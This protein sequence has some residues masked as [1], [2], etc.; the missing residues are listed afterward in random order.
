MTD[1]IDDEKPMSTEEY[2][3][4]LRRQPPRRPAGFEPCG[5]LASVRGQQVGEPGVA[6]RGAPGQPAVE[7]DVS[8][9]L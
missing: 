1:P 2:L 9:L 6:F 4:Y 7:D 8:P 5:R 3:A